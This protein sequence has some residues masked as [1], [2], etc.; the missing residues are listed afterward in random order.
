MNWPRNHWPWQMS[1]V[2]ALTLVC[3]SEVSRHYARA[4]WCAACG[5][6]GG[7]AK[8]GGGAKSATL[9]GWFSHGLC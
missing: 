1:E 7:V 4:R 3:N 5:S 2:E 8:A 9:T 6:V